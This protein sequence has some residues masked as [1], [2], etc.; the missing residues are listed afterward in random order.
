MSQTVLSRGF[1]VSPW[2]IFQ[3]VVNGT[4]DALESF[5]TSACDSASRKR[6]TSS[7][8]GG[9]VFMIAN[10]PHTVRSMQPH[11]VFAPNYRANMEPRDPKTYLWANICALMKEPAPSI[12]RAAKVLKIGRGTV[13]RIKEAQ[14]SVGLDVLRDVAAALKTEVWT[15]LTPPQ[16]ASKEAHLSWRDEAFLLAEGHPRAEWR[17]VLLMFCDKV[18]R[19]C[20]EKQAEREQTHTPQKSEGQTLLR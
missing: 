11:S 1:G 2:R 18:D 16:A 19:H 6:R 5:V 12:D 20:S 9:V 13:Q 8:L 15:L 4:P 17:E 10:I 7:G 14:T 3:S